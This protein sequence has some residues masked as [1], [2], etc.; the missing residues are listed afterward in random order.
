[1]PARQV[2]PRDVSRARFGFA[3][4]CS[5]FVAEPAQVSGSCGAPG[6]AQCRRRVRTGAA[7]MSSMKKRHDRNWACSVRVRLLKAIL[8]AQIKKASDMHPFLE[9]LIPI[10]RAHAHFANWERA[11]HRAEFFCKNR[12]PD[13]HPLRRVLDDITRELDDHRWAVGITIRDVAKRYGDFRTFVNGCFFEDAADWFR[14][15]QYIYWDCPSI[16]F[17]RGIR[18][19]HELY[20][21][22][23]ASF[24]DV[25]RSGHG[26]LEAVNDLVEKVRPKSKPN[27]VRKTKL[28][29]KDCQ[30]LGRQ[31][32]RIKVC[33]R[34]RIQ[35][36]LCLRRKGLPGPLGGAVLGFLA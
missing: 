9:E 12:F 33:P 28:F 22:G 19:S 15:G 4:Q 16:S 35:V 14:N 7:D 18:R 8:F 6:L 30:R 17:G 11:K 32:R 24:H 13:S 36:L 29:D 10:K 20:I 2:F 26:F 25:E 27:L 1:M 34:D 5:G 3:G 21:A 23:V 31:L